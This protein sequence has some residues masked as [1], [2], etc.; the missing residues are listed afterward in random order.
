MDA[1]RRKGHG[2]VVAFLTSI[3]GDGQQQP[4]ESP[5]KQNAFSQPLNTAPSAS[6]SFGMPAP[7]TSPFGMT[8]PSTPSFGMTVPSASPSFGMTAPSAS[9]SFGMT[10]PSPQSFGVTAPSSSLA[11]GRAAPSTHAAADTSR[12]EQSQHIETTQPTT[13]L[14]LH[15]QIPSFMAPS[16]SGSFD[17]TDTDVSIWL[18]D[19]NYDSLCN[20]FRSRG[21]TRLR[22]FRDFFGLHDLSGLCV[23]FPELTKLQLFTMKSLLASLSDDKISSYASKVVSNRSSNSTNQGIPISA[24]SSSPFSLPVGENKIKK[25]V[26]L[27]MK[28]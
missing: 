2:D 12:E 23:E 27:K 1:A 16:F 11:F 21:A 19:E 15:L 6:P 8:A 22:E 14:W 17:N 4:Q 13:D 24:S 7:S 3:S 18:H 20:Y 5:S 9:P 25:I 28:E 10:V 26:S